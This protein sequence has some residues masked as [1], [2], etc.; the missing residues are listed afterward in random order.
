MPTEKITSL[1]ELLNLIPG[2]KEELFAQLDC[3]VR[4]YLVKN[5]GLSFGL[6][7]NPPGRPNLFKTETIQKYSS[8][9]KLFKK[10]SLP[11]FSLV[12]T[13]GADPRVEENDKGMIKELNE[14]TM[15][16]IDYPWVKMGIVY[17]RCYGGASIV[18]FPPFFGGEEVWALEGANIGIMGNQIIS[19][20]LGSSKRLH[21]EW[22]ENSADESEDLSDFVKAGIID[23]VISVSE[24]NSHFSQMIS[25]IS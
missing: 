3:A 9:L 4:V 1:E 21:S 20:L 18:S 2:D 23:K 14:L 22:K 24:F 11:V 15:Q 17:G 6:L 25:S 7:V 19:K 12:D 8:A 13:P 16:I 5:K 10:L